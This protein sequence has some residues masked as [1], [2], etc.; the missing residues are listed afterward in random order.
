MPKSKKQKDPNRPKRSLTAFMYYS[1][2]R[3]GQIRKEK[4]EMSMIEISKMV[5]DEW[6]NLSTESKQPYHDKAGVAHEAYCIEKEKYEKTKLKRPRSAYALFMKENR[7]VVAGE[8]PNVPPKDLMKFIAE[9]WKE[10]D[11]TTKN[12]YIFMAKQDRER[13]LK[14][15]ST[16][17]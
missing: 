16:Q 5:G 3:R 7:S 14:D 8:H 6:K 15:K 10:I 17:V 9:K 13:W 1:G 12:K 4:P 11:D 2:A